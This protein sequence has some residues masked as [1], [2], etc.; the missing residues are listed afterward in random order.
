MYDARQWHAIPVILA[1]SAP[2]VAYGPSH[3]AALAVAVI[4]IVAILAFARWAP[5]RLDRAFAVAIVVVALP[6]QL[7]QFTPAE[8]NLQTSLPLQLCDWAW[9]VAAIALWTRSRLAATITYLWGLTL[10][11][12]A[13]ATPALTTAFPGLRWW[14]FWA[15]HLLIIWA[16]VYVIWAMK[17]R[18]T[19]QTYRRT[20]A[21]TLAWA[22]AT[23]IFNIV[24]GTNYGYLNGKPANRSALDLLGPWPWYVIFEIEIVCAVWAA[25]TWP[26]TRQRDAVPLR[27]AAG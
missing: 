16:A 18:P 5:R 8:W 17:L 4:G 13:M 10:T 19:W 7:V 6:L 26:W 23:F 25:L 22:V 20:V 14:L 27:Q 24:V 2:F 9:L 3:L 1:P 11:T 15:M 12:Q 21:I